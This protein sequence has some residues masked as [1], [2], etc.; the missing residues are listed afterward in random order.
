MSVC[1]SRGARNLTSAL[2]NKQYT[3]HDLALGTF[4]SDIVC[5]SEGSAP[6]C[7][8]RGRLVLM[9]A[10]V[11]LLVAVQA[12]VDKI[13]GDVVRHWPLASRFGDHER[14]IMRAQEVNK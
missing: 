14:H 9:A 7:P 10:A 6:R 8:A 13:S 1:A 5:A 4:R 3:S 12:H 11:K 2:S